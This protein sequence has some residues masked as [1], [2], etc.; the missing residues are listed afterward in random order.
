MLVFL[1]GCLQ[2]FAQPSLYRQYT[3]TVTVPL[4]YQITAPTA[5]NEAPIPTT[6][7]GFLFITRLYVIGLSSP[8]GLVAT[9]ITKT[10]ASLLPQWRKNYF[11]ACVLPTGGIVLYGGQ[12]IEKVTNAGLTVW[13][14]SLSSGCMLNDAI[15]YN[16]KIRFV[17]NLLS[18]QTI[19]NTITQ[20][21]TTDGCALELDTNGTFQS[22]QIFQSSLINSVGTFTYRAS[23]NFSRIERDALGNFF[24]YSNWQTP[25]GIPSQMALA[26]FD[27]SFVNLWA[28]TGAGYY[29]SISITDIDVLSNGRI[30]ASGRSSG[31]TPLNYNALAAFFKISSNGTVVQEKYF[32]D[33][34]LSSDLCKLPSGNYIASV[35]KYDSLFTFE[36][37]T[38]LTLSWH[39]YRAKSTSIGNSA[40]KNGLLYT[41]FH[42]NFK[43]TVISGSLSGQSCASIPFPAT[44]PTATL[45]LQNFTLNPITSTVSLI[46]IAA[47]PTLAV[48]Y[49]DTCICS[50]YISVS[51]SI[52]CVGGSATLTAVPAGSINWYLAAGGGPTL[53]TGPQYT[54]SAAT[55]T[56]LTYYIDNLI[57]GTNLPR[58]PVSINV[59]PLPNLMF[60]PPNP[61]VCL[62]STVAVATAGALYYVWPGT[63]NQ[64]SVN[65]FTPTATT[66]YTVTGAVNASCGDTKTIQIT[67]V[68]LQ[69]VSISGPSVACLGVPT[70][71]T[72]NGSTNSVWY[73]NNQTTGLTALGSASTAVFTPTQQSN[74]M[75]VL[76][77]PATGGSC[78]ATNTLNVSVGITPTISAVA[79]PTL[80]CGSGIATLS[81]TGANNFTWIN[82]GSGPT[83]TL[84]V[85]NSTSF[86]VLAGTAPC[87]AS[88]TVAVQVQAIP[89]VSI[90]P[91]SVTV[92]SG[93]SLSFTALGA[94]TYTWNNSQIATTYSNTWPVGSSTLLVSGSNGTCTATSIASIQVNVTPTVNIYQYNPYLC[95]GKVSTY[96]AYGANTFTWNNSLPSNTFSIVGSN[97][98]L[99]TLI[100]EINGCFS[101]ATYS[102][103]AK[104]NPTVAVSASADTVC[105]AQNVIVV[106]S[107]TGVAYWNGSTPSPTLNFYPTS[108]T[109]VVMQGQSQFGCKARDS[110]IITVLPRPTLTVS[111]KQFTICAGDLMVHSA[112][113]AVTYTWNNTLNGDTVLTYPIANQAYTVVGTGSNGCT[114]STKVTVYV[115][116]CLGIYASK[117]TNATLEIYPNPSSGVF[118]LNYVDVTTAK[119]LLV[120]SADGRL[121]FKVP[122]TAAAIDL[123]GYAAGVYYVR[124]EN[125]V[126][127][128][129]LVRG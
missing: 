6:D 45:G 83:K 13:T 76:F 114:G 60:A 46:T 71:Y 43:S 31:S 54:V 100:G 73:L 101:T 4:P 53:S 122:S 22:H 80:L 67:V 63:A 116:N 18:V 107:G 30:M 39:N 14:R 37:D 25:Y 113:G 32:P 34:T 96:T 111:P 65:V 102:F 121:L 84:V 94:S 3:P 57:C 89:Q 77:S 40:I 66:V 99:I 78:T 75:L 28:K 17:G 115:E 23:A 81:A 52:I 106:A 12:S 29:S 69:N 91:S 95:L 48:G 92:C 109:T 104:P 27:A 51:N 5:A 93:S 120:Y 7:G 26:K 86:A 10:D 98:T 11:G 62:G 15:S 1:L 55:P 24:V 90:T 123:S 103:E 38:L 36:L 105:S 16:S 33:R 72:A 97:D 82:L 110:V 58:V 20:A 19:P 119:P 108:T 42:N 127:R 79:F 112:S 118:Y 70:T 74:Y 126:G 2:S 49:Q 50:P 128:W 64:S 87:T 9:T 56:T 21:Y 129:R 117:T 68:P 35:F 88:A 44:F 125:G 59:Q 8:G 47:T 41:A 124:E 61:S 85:S